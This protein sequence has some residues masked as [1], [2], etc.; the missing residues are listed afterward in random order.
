MKIEHVALWTTKL[1]VMRDFYV[2]YFGGRAGEKYVNPKKNFESYFISFSE[3]SRL[4]I[5]HSPDVPQSLDD[6]YQQF[7]GYIHM[8]F[9]VATQG[10][11]DSLTNTLNNDGYQVV[12]MPRLTG[13]GYYES[14]VLDPDGNRV[15]IVAQPD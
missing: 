3:G 4:E 5:M 15:E 12:G 2:T 10:E 14:C 13:D 11:V 9:A 8:A 7:T 6:V 1:E